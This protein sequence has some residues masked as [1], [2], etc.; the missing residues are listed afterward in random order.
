MDDL[1]VLVVLVVLIG[2]RGFSLRCCWHLRLIQK[3]VAP[4]WVALI[5]V[6]DHLEMVFHLCHLCVGFLPCHLLMTFRSF[7]LSLYRSY[8]FCPLYRLCRLCCLSENVLESLWTLLQYGV[9]VVENDL[10]VDTDQY[11]ETSDV[12]EIAPFGYPSP[13]VFRLVT[14]RAVFVNSSVAIDPV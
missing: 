7:Q 6:D 3:F 12:L 5:Q 9:M 8:L 2:V 10:L 11:Q 14:V 13:L 1:L 4:L